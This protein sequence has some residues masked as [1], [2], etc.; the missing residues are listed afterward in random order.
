MTPDGYDDRNPAGHWHETGP[1]LP[2]CRILA[3]AQADLT[4]ACDEMGFPCRLC[5]GRAGAVYCCCVA[6]CGAA[7]CTGA[8]LAGQEAGR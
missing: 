8:V 2:G 1:C 7:G 3:T 5:H 4:L 6:H